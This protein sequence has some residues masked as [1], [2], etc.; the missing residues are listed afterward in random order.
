MYI[1]YRF[2]KNKKKWFKKRL[3]LGI[4]TPVERDKKIKILFFLQ[5]G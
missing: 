1:K 5:R 4:K 2:A 3:F